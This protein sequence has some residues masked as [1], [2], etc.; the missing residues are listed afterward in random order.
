MSKRISFRVDASVYIGTG[1]VMRCL[2]LAESLRERGAECHFVTRDLPGHMGSLIKDSG[3]IVSLLPAPSGLVPPHPPVNAGWLGVCWKQDLADTLA[4]INKSD[5]IIVDHYALDSRWE[6]GLG[7]LVNQVMVIDD[8]ADRPHSASLLLDQNLGREGRDYDALIP[9]TCSLLTGSHYALLRPQ[10]AVAREF[11]LARRQ[12]AK[13]AHVMIAMGGADAVD[14]TSSILRILRSANLPQ[15]LRISVVM[16]SRAPMLASVRELSVLMP[17]PT[18]VLVDVG[19]VAAL[20]TDSDLAIVAG[21][22]TNWERCCLGLPG[23][24][25]ETAANQAHSVA[26]LIGVRAAVGAGQLSDPRFARRLLRAVDQMLD[27]LLRI[28]IS[29]HASEV[30]SGTGAAIIAEILGEYKCK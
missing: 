20:M 22:S 26:A 24:V 5:W 10:F 7:K 21:G 18:E 16:G 30:C 13:L 2:T 1:H 27:P 11:S 6:S 19:D 17:W 12:S 15:E 25:V 4:V 8:L 29:T 28:E 23:I 3:F 14:A 9:S